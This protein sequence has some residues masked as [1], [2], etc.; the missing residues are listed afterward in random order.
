MA[1][2]KG[3]SGGHNRKSIAAHLAAGTHRSDRH[4]PRP[5][6]D[7]PPA[8]FDPN[9]TPPRSL[10]ARGRAV[11]R[12]IAPWLVEVHGTAAAPKLWLLHRACDLLETAADAADALQEHGLT[13]TDA[14]GML[15][16]RPE[17]AIQQ[18]AIAELRACLRDLGVMD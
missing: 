10:G 2:V 11:W 3:R 4:G 14:A 8:T 12:H 17:V 9:P 1:G 5:P 15:Q 6:A 7:A 13:M 18:G 16:P